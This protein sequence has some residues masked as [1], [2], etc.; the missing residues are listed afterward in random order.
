MNDI[1]ITQ[2]TKEDW[3]GWAG[4]EKFENGELP[5]IY[6]HELKNAE[7]TI[8]GDRNGVQVAV[9]SEYDAGCETIE[10]YY[11]WVLSSRKEWTP[12]QVEGEMRALIKEL[13]PAEKYGAEIAYTLDHIENYEFCGIC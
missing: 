11:T 5:L 3:Y 12:I 2:F 13:N 10:G 4:A 8:I 1:K 9:Y 6:K 7:L